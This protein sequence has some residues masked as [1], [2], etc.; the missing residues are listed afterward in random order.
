MSKTFG[1]LCSHGPHCSE[2]MGTLVD[3]LAE[4]PSQPVLFTY[5]KLE[6]LTG[7][8]GSLFVE[9]PQDQPVLR[10]YPQALPPPWCFN[11][12]LIVCC[13]SVRCVWGWDT[14]SVYVEVRGQLWRRFFPHLCGSIAWTLPSRL[15]WQ[16]LSLAEPSCRFCPCYFKVNYSFEVFKPGGGVVLLLSET[17]IQQKCERSIGQ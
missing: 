3:A 12:C 6:R 4:L 11:Y 10:S 15:T 14:R 7:Q 13:V 17:F 5:R 16:V 8:L 9:P 2:A 1:N